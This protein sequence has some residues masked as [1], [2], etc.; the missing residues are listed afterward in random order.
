MTSIDSVVATSMKLTCAKEELAEK[1]QVAG[2]G[3][4]TRASVQILAG[5]LLRAAS[6]QLSLSATD[7][8]ISLRL[9]SMRRWRTRA[10]WSFPAGYWWTSSACFPPAR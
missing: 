5:I 9:L 8:E 3:V 4:S 6:G 1:L 10:R 2:R 7:M